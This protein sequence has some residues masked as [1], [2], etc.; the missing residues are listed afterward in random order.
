MTIG[1]LIYILGIL[2]FGFGTFYFD[3]EWRAILITLGAIWLVGGFLLSAF[4]SE[5]K[6]KAAAAEFIA[7]AKVVSKATNASAGSVDSYGY[8]AGITR[9][10][11][12]FEFNGR[13]E[14]FEVNIAQY[15][16]IVENETGI[17][18][19][20]EVDDRY[21]YINFRPNKTS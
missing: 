7:Q 10:F 14:N 4:S 8:R 18:T 17:L 1:K 16:S 15:N 6:K 21:I 19:Y 11:A 2:A 20:K 13:R 5:A 9:Y 3:G 12:S